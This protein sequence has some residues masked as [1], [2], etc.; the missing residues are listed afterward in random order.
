[1]AKYGFPDFVHEGLLILS[2][3]EQNKINLLIE[4]LKKSNKATT[5]QKLTDYLAEKKIYTKEQTDKIVKT[6]FSL[7]YLKEKENKNNISELVQDLYESFQRTV[8]AKRV[9]IISKENI[10]SLLTIP[11][12]GISFKAVGLLREYDKVFVDS[13]IITDIRP[14]FDNNIDSNID[15]G[16]IIHS[17]KLEYH[18]GQQPHGQIFLALDANNLNALKDQIIRAQKKEKT[19]KASLKNLLFIDAD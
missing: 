2:K 7:Y 19:I 10:K 4:N 11:S 8:K 3:S 5:P 9:K 17:L 14:S 16:I 15:V 13:R 6:L 18:Q 12:I 1:M